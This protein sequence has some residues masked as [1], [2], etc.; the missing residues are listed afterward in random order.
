MQ[1]SQEKKALRLWNA[2]QLGIAYHIYKFGV[3]LTKLSYSL[4]IALF[5][6][7]MLSGTSNDIMNIS[8]PLALFIIAQIFRITGAILFLSQGVDVLNTVLSH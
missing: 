2:I 8:F 3:W 6:F 7:A 1:I 4:A 5:I